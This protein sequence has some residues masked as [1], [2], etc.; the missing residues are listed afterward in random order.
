[1]RR[2]LSALAKP[3][4]DTTGL[5]RWM[6]VAGVLITAIFVICALFAPLLAPYGFAQSSAHGVEFP[7]VGHP[8]SS[9]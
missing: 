5:A 7:K 6:L 4:T 3:F 2:L 9:H 1:M 8:S